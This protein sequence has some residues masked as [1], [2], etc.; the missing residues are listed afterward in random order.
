MQDAYRPPHGVYSIYQEAHSSLCSNL[1][2]MAGFGIRAIIEAVCKD[3]SI[4]GRTLQDRINGLRDS[5]LITS[6]A[7]D[8]LHNLRFMGN[9]AAHEMRAHNMKELGAAFT[10]AEHLLQTVYVIPHHASNL[11]QQNG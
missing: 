5:G 3:K 6:D 7:A 1:R 8:I 2:I 11:P 9:A 4:Q 10:V